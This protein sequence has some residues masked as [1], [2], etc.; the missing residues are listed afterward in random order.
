M[1]YLKD[2]KFNENDVLLFEEKILD[3]QIALLIKAII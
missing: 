2:F 3:Y 1:I